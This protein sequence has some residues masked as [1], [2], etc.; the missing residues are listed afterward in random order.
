MEYNADTG[1]EGREYYDGSG[2]LSGGIDNE[3]AAG[4]KCF[5]ANGPGDPKTVTYAIE[6]IKKLL[7]K[8]SDIR[9]LSR[10]SAFSPRFRCENLQTEVRTSRRQSAGDESADK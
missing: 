5:W 10:S 7:G 1:I 9:D 6:N 4:R 2:G 8:D 3:D